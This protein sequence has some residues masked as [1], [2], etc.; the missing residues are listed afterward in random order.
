[1]VANS[2]LT[3]QPPPWVSAAVRIGSNR[4]GLPSSEPSSFGA[5]PVA[6][7]PRDDGG[8]VGRPA[9][10]GGARFPR[11]LAS[12]IAAEIPQ[13]AAADHRRPCSRFA[14]TTRGDRMPQ[15]SR[16]CNGDPD[17]QGD[18]RDSCSPTC[19]GL[20]NVNRVSRPTRCPA[21]GD[22][23]GWLLVPRHRH[24]ARWTCRAPRRR[25]TASS[26]R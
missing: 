6:R 1:M 25:H 10:V 4:G 12:G 18:A 11:G 22:R 20:R 3:P 14:R 9:A 5:S 8:D 16:N 13:T 2:W 26:C 7:A 19:Q 15:R 17:P 24:P 21:G 23:G